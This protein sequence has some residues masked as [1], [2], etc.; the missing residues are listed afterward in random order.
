MRTR[1][2]T[3]QTHP[4]TSAHKKHTYTHEHTKHMRTRE[5]TR[6]THP[7]TSALKKHTYISTQ[8]TCTDT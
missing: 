8:D 2:Y 4:D 3:L 5:Y 7:D 1:E 6:Q